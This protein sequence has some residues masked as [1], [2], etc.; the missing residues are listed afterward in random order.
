ML[1]ATTPKELVLA[2]FESA[3]ALFEAAEKLHGA[4]YTKYDCHSPFPIHGM[5]EA[6]GLKRSPIGYFVAICGL[7][8]MVGSMMMMWWMSTVDYPLVISGKPLFSFQAYIPIAFA[9]T[10]LMAAFGAFFGMLGI[11]KLPQLFHTIFHSQQFGAVTT[12]GFFV[13]IESSDPKY[14]VQN[15]QSF[16]ES[17]GGVSIEVLQQ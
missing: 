16:L 17:I 15:T 13:S 6:M 8:G 5:D 11:N 1:K 2:R 9:L 7:A 10:I 14:D 12:G 3:Q 4:G